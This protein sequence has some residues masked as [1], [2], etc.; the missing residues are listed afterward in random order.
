MKL[1]VPGTLK[2]VED[3]KKL[4]RHHIAE[5]AQN[6]PSVHSCI[7]RQI[8]LTMLKWMEDIRWDF[9]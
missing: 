3:T 1:T 8:H 2:V 6:S 7:C 4:E 9:L 5:P